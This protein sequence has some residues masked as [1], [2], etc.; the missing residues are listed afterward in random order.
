MSSSISPLTTLTGSSTFASDLQAAANRALTI[1]SLPKQ[2]LQA[3]QNRVNSQV[4]ELGRLGSLFNNVQSSLQ[5]LDS[6]TSAGALAASVSDTSVLQANVTGTALP[7]HLYRRS[8]G[9]WLVGQRHQHRAA[10]S[11]YRSVR[12]K[13]QPEQFLHLDRGRHNLHHSA[14]RAE[15]ELAGHGHQCERRA[16]P[17]GCHQSGLA[18]LA[19][20]SSGHSEHHSG[21]GPDSVERWDERPA[22]YP[23]RG[24]ERILHGQR[25]AAR[26]NFD[27]RFH[28]HDRP[29]PGRHARQ[30]RH[31]QHH[32]LHQP[33][34]RVERSFVAWSTPTTSQ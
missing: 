24:L 28:G 32:G 13:H 27:Q 26:R 33:H 22:E 19:G 12:A 23:E 31:R 21:R 30:A 4:S 11:G 3:D 2:L 14:S 34:C 25:P 8:L 6:A 15:P 29:R 18:F 5:S 7:G 20:L 1:A 17:G 9:C 10:H 16:G